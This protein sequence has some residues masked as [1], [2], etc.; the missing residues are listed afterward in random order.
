MPANCS[1]CKNRSNNGSKTTFHKFPSKDKECLKKWVEFVSIARGKGFWKPTVNSKL[2]SLHFEESSFRYFNGRVYLNSGAAPTV[3]DIPEHL[4]KGT[5]CT[6]CTRES[7]V[8]SVSSSAV[9]SISPEVPTTVSTSQLEERAFDYEGNPLNSAPVK[10]AKLELSR[11]DEEQLRKAL[12]PPAKGTPGSRMSVEAKEA[13]GKRPIIVHVTSLNN[14]SESLGRPTRVKR[15]PEKFRSGEYDRDFA[16][17]PPRKAPRVSSKLDDTGPGISDDDDFGSES[18]D[19]DAPDLD[20]D[21]YEGSDAEIPV[22]TSSSG[23]ATAYRSQP[24]STGQGTKSVGPDGKAPTPT[25]SKSMAGTSAGTLVELCTQLEE[26]RARNEELS[27]QLTKAKEV[28]ENQNRNIE[29]LEDIINGL[30]QRVVAMAKKCG[31]ST[32]PVDSSGD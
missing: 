9:V 16:E 5:R 11:L 13:D 26:Q 28:I 3:F 6:I 32:K 18:E 14:S 29:A 2:C 12:A 31:A 17:E 7:D 20:E 8:S 23:P 24:S 22:A 10:I 27:R 30:R 19:V 25:A 1:A 21:E 4:Q 15:L